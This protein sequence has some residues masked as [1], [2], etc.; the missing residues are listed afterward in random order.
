MIHEKVVPCGK[1][2]LIVILN[3]KGVVLRI[4]C[5]N[6]FQVWKGLNQRKEKW[7]TLKAVFLNGI[8]DVSGTLIQYSD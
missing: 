2:K 3:T 5:D 7:L 4:I 8:N 6:Y 1:V